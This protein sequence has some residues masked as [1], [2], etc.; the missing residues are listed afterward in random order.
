[1]TANTKT[2]PLALHSGVVV[3]FMS[4]LPATWASA[5]EEACGALASNLSGDWVGEIRKSITVV[6]DKQ[7]AVKT[8]TF[9]VTLYLNL[10]FK[11][12]EGDACVFKAGGDMDIKPHDYQGTSTNEDVDAGGYCARSA[13]VPLNYHSLSISP[14]SEKR[15]NEEFKLEFSFPY[16]RGLEFDRTMYLLEH[17]EYEMVTL[18]T[19]NRIVLQAGELKKKSE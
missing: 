2:S 19:D 15:K 3:F 9:D 16:T 12:V 14:L 10:N 5:D 1:M 7:E 4:L 6:K 18:T 11:H 8:C 17:T 13:S